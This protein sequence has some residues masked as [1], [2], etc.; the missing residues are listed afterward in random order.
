[1]AFLDSLCV[2]VCVRVFKN[3][4]AVIRSRVFFVLGFLFVKF[5]ALFL[6][7][8]FCNSPGCK[9]IRLNHVFNWIWE[10]Y[11]KNIIFLVLRQES[12][13]FVVSWVTA[14]RAFHVFHHC[15][16]AQVW[17]LMIQYWFRMSCEIVWHIMQWGRLRWSLK[18]S[19]PIAKGSMQR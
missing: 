7:K 3:C 10:I 6:N 8:R 11:D 5:I 15:F 18:H 17:Y 9:K 16:E 19:D 12:T 2:R 13:D 1:M 4:C 14:M